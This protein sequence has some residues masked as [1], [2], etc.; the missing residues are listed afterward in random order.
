MFTSNKVFNTLDCPQKPFGFVGVNCV[1]EILLMRNNFQ[2]VQSI[3]GA[4]KVFVVYFQS[5]FNTS[6]KRLPHHSVH[7]LPGVFSLFAQISNIVA[8]DQSRRQ[9]SVGR[10]TNPSFTLLDRMRCGYASAQELRD[11]LKGSTVLEHLLRFWNFGGVKGFASGSSAHVT[12]IADLV[13]VFKAKN[14]FPRF[15][16]QLPFKLNRSIA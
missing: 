16:V 9:H 7:A 1:L 15:H 8:F 6:I 13:Q 12:V 2:I 11:L 3:V 4:V 10:V 14:W 5:A